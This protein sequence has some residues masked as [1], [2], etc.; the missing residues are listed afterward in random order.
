VSSDNTDGVHTDEP[1]RPKKDNEGARELRRLYPAR[2]GSAEVA[3]LLDADP[4]AVSRWFSGER[5]PDTKMRAALE[6]RLGVDWRL[7]DRECEHE[8]SEGRDS[9]GAA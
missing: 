6:E 1:K 2:G 3:R 8:E 4:S 5:A 7:F 9:K